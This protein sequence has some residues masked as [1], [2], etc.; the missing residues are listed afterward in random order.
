[1]ISH[2]QVRQARTITTFDELIIIYIISQA[3]NST[4]AHTCGLQDLPLRG[5]KN[6]V[7]PVSGIHLPLEG[8]L[9]SFYTNF[10]GKALDSNVLFNMVDSL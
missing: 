6:K 4:A 7:I 2:A 9:G 1:M 8:G 5:E 3:T 10:S